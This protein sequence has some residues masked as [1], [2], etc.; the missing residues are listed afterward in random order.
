M[1]TASTLAY[2]KVCQLAREHVKV[3]LTGQGADEPFA[4]YPRHLGE[5]YSAAYRFIPGIMR[6]Q[7]LRP[8]AERLPRNEQAKR[9]VRS[10]GITDPLARMAAVYTVINMPLKRKLYQ[11]GLMPTYS[12]L[13]AVQLWQSDVSGLDG[14]S[15]MLYVDARFSLA[16]NLFTRHGRNFFLEILMILIMIYFSFCHGFVSF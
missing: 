16:D 6:N 9:T 13:D 14:L 11:D 3:V 2:Y 10:L 1:A 12:D 7:L 8:L 15:Q 5:Y 4:G